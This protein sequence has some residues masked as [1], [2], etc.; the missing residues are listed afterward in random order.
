MLGRERAMRDWS[1]TAPAGMSL[2]MPPRSSNFSAPPAGCTCCGS[3]PTKGRRRHARRGCGRDES[4]DKPAPCQA[5]LGGLDQPGP[6]RTTS[7][8]PS[9]RHPHRDSG[10]P[11]RRTHPRRTSR[12][13]AH[14]RRTFVFTA[15]NEKGEVRDRRAGSLSRRYE[16]C[17]LGAGAGLAAGLQS[18]PCNPVGP[19]DST[20]GP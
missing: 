15:A 16:L 6:R 9:G 19:V 18:L 17:F 20:A 1:H 14:I 4:G 11:R 12:A 13:S 5:A 2:R 8:L 7:P 3:C 10:P